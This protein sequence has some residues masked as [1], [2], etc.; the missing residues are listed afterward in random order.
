VRIAAG[1]LADGGEAVAAGHPQ[2]QQDQARIEALG[3]AYGLVAVGCLADHLD[4]GHRRQQRP[5]AS[6]EHRVVVGEQDGDRLSH[7]SSSGR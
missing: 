6:A 2:V 3:Q 4:A 7:D 5:E 1:Q